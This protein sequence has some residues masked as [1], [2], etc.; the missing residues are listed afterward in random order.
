M[1][2]APLPGRNAV[3][4]VATPEGGPRDYRKVH[5]ILDGTK[6]GFTGTIRCVGSRFPARSQFKHEPFALGLL[7]HV[8]RVV[9]AKWYVPLSEANTPLLLDLSHSP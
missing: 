6:T 7:G 3:G 4:R 8:P 5:K 9:K 2:I 1:M